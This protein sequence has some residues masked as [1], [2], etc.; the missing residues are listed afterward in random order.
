[1]PKEIICTSDAPQNPAYSQ[2]VKTGSTVYVAGTI[3]VDVATG[4]FAGP[5]IQ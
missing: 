5:T 1:M 3:G 2:A 4:Q